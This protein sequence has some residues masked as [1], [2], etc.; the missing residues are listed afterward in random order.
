MNIK[1]IN[2][3]VTFH[4]GEAKFGIPVLSTREIVEYGKI[5]P[6]PES[7]DFIEGVINIRGT[8]VP[9]VDLT[10]KFFGIRAKITET[11]SIIIVEPRV[12][13][14]QTLMGLI[15]DVV[16][17]VLEIKQENLEPAPKYGSKLK[18]EYIL[19]VASIDGDFILILDIDKA[20]SQIEIS[21]DFAAMLS[22]EKLVQELKQE[23]QKAD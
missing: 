21:E 2:K 16:N 6:I 22:K 14:E 23:A 8:V 11:T 17:D 5:T 3:F 19:N 15:V 20:L 7:P 12:D 4:I 1:S 18:S 10:K 9:V 13:G